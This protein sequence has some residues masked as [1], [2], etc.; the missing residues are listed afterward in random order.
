MG[1]DASNRYLHTTAA[2]TAPRT[3]ATTKAQSCESAPAGDKCRPEA[4]CRVDRSPGDR[5]PDQMD[6]GK[7]ETDCNPGKPGRC[8]FARGAKDHREEHEREDD[9][10][11]EPRR[12]RESPGRCGTVPVLP[13]A[14]SGKG[15]GRV[16]GHDGKQEGRCDDRADALDDDVDSGI[17]AADPAV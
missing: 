3:G 12:K 17:P 13:D 15:I 14:V 4:P 9:F 7:G 6:N 8:R 1:V 5:D 2:I 11:K 16:P 10:S